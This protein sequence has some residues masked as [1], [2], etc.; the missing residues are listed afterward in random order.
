MKTLRLLVAAALLACAATQLQAQT[1]LQGGIGKT[2]A[3]NVLTTL[4][5]QSSLQNAIIR[6]V[7]NHNV[8]VTYSTSF[9]RLP[10][11]A[12]QGDNSL[13]PVLVVYNFKMKQKHNKLIDDIVQAMFNQCNNP[14][15]YRIESYAASSQQQPRAWDLLYGNNANDKIEI[16]RNKIYSYAFVNIANGVR[17]EPT[18]SQARTCYCIEWRTWA[19]TTD[20]RV[21]ITYAAIPQ[22]VQYSGTV[23]PITN[24]PVKKQLET[25]MEI[26]DTAKANSFPYEL[27]KEGKLA[28]PTEL[29]QMK[30]ALPL[31]NALRMAL[32][33]AEPDEQYVIAPLLY[34][35]IKDAVAKD[36][37]NK[38]ERDMV[39]KQLE[40]MILKSGGG[41]L[42][43]QATADYLRLAAKVLSTNQTP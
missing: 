35:V 5:T 43:S 29:L 42:D 32:T 1:R 4:K 19:G 37:L 22:V 17:F 9:G 13:K 15:C 34:C 28:F 23:K 10:C 8:S 21:I 38:D 6:L 39:R 24:D 16:G 2:N 40:R 11:D 36:M 12:I 27:L 31:I 3:N 18:Q 33:E 7:E 25:T 30:E 26:T 41:N 14:A 20:G